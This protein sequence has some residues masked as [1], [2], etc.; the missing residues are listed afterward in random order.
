MKLRINETLISQEVIES[1][2]DFV[3]QDGLYVEI[4]PSNNGFYLKQVE[5]NL[6][7][8]NIQF[9]QTENAFWIY[10]FDEQITITR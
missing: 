4:D 6:K 3:S 1:C 7:S 8:L 2:F 10:P 5:E 9:S